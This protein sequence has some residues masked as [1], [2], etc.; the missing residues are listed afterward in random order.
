MAHLIKVTEVWRAA[1]LVEADKMAADFRDDDTFILQR[2]S[3]VEKE[4]KEKG[5]VVDEWIQV[6]AVKVFNVEKEPDSDVQPSYK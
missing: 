2:Y 3:T 5:E 1:D 6:T 4:R